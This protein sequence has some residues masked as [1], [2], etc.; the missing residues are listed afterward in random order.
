M[1]DELVYGSQGTQFFGRHAR[2]KKVK[3]GER[4]FGA[5]GRKEK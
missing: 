2:E 4:G 1:G 3:Q 5:K